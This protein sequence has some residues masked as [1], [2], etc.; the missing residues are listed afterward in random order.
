M[1]F[2]YLYWSTA[3]GCQPTADEV[4]DILAASRRNNTVA[5]ITGLLLLHEGSYFQVLEGEETV[6]RACFARIGRD[7][8]HHGLVTLRAGAEQ[9]RAF[10]HWR[11]GFARLDSLPGTCRASALDLAKLAQ[12]GEVSGEPRIDRLIQTFLAGFRSLG[13][14]AGRELRAEGLTGQSRTMR[15]GSAP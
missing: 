14:E 8:R 3:R 12:R 15:D 5:D 6:V 7:P 9:E 2:R 4:S 11:M 10:P 1:I 13:Y